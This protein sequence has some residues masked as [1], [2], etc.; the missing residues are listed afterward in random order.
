MMAALRSTRLDNCTIQISAQPLSDAGSCRTGGD[1]LARRGSVRRRRLATAVGR[2]IT[3]L[4]AT[5]RRMRVNYRALCHDEATVGKE[6]Q[7]LDQVLQLLEKKAAG[8]AA[9]CASYIRQP[10]ALLEVWLFVHMCL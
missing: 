3:A 10:K 1:R 2:A 4:Q 6:A 9:N 8:L 5:G 7:A